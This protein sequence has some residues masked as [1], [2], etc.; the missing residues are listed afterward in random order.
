MEKSIE[1]KIDASVM[2]IEEARALLQEDQEFLNKY[3]TGVYA[4]C[5]L[6]PVGLGKVWKHLKE[7]GMPLQD[8][9]KAHCTI[10]Y[11]KTRPV[12]EPTPIELKGE[13]QPIG[14][15]IFGKGTKDE[16]YVLVLKIKSKALDAAHLK[17]IRELGIKPT[18]NT[19]E[20]HIT[21]TYDINRILPGIKKLSTKQKKTITNIFDILVPE[22]PKSIRILRSD[23]EPR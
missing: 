16:P 8:I 4:S 3:R 7:V 5:T 20:P 17:Y 1:N 11:S 21:L 19:F 14:F 9:N 18:Y 10:I 2:S 12:Q 13:V 23:I 22:L 15:G 6:D